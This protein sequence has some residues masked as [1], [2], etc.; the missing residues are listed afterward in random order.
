MTLGIACDI[1]RSYLS[2]KT[3]LTW[4]YSTALIYFK[5]SGYLAW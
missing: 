1:K 2:I 3:R 4:V 5:I